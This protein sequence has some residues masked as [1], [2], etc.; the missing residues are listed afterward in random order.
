VQ[1]LYG[2]AFTNINITQLHKPMMSQFDDWLVI[3]YGKTMTVF[4]K[5]EFYNQ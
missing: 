5:I 4:K 1:V 2:R 3:G